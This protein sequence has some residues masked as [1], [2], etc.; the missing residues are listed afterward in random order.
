M[1]ISD[2]SSDVCSSD[3]FRRSLRNPG[4]LAYYFVYAREGTS[5]E[6][7]AGAAGLRW[8]IEECFLR[9]K[10]DP[11]LA[12]CEAR[13][14]HGWPRHMTLVMAAAALQI[15]RESWRERVGQYV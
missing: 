4:E 5:L 14:W 7:L 2:W 11:G 6:E 10:D 12:H 9:S 1:R 13:S 8:T 3:L 15:G